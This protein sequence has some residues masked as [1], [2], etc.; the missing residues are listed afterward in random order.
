M[1]WK[2][3]A[4][5]TRLFSERQAIAQTVPEDSPSPVEISNSISR[6]RLELFLSN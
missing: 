2:P 4:G 6:D 5:R 3:A 1:P